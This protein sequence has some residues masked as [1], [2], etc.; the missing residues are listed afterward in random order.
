M[1]RINGLIAAVMAV[2]AVGV[3]AQ[4]IV[5]GGRPGTDFLATR[6][7]TRRCQDA[8]TLPP[9]GHRVCLLDAIHFTVVGQTRAGAAALQ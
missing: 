5:I 8:R 6:T 1:G 3:A 9:I 4:Y 2:A 7:E